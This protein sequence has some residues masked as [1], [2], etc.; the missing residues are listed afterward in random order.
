[1]KHKNL[2][3]LVECA[4]M[5]ALATVLSLLK[6]TPPFLIFGGSITLLSM[7]PIAV[8]SC[9]HGIAVGLG[10][11]F[12]YAALQLVL[13]LSK[14]LTWGLTPAVLVACFFLDYL[15]AF[16]VI[17]FAGIFRKKGTTG[18]LL[19]TALALFL[20]FFSHFLSGLV[21]WGIPSEYVEQ[22]HNRTAL[23][24]LAYNGSYMLPEIMFTV[25]ALFFFLQNAQFRRFLQLPAKN[26]SDAA[27]PQA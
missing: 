21:L 5:I 17:G 14:I 13:D 8:I 6:I 4:I 22:F 7:L 10:T 15:L 9:R 25:L 11:G 3:T 24:S 20:R 12:V 2:Q 19:G 27:E 18:V 1:M 23:Y 26:A 16:T